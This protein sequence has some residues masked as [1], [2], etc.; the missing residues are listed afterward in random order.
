[1]NFPVIYRAGNARLREKHPLIALPKL[2]HYVIKKHNMFFGGL[3]MELL[4][5]RI[6]KSGKVLP[7][8]VLKIDSFLN[9]QM[10]PQLMHEMALR[11]EGV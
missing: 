6:L 4:E 7:G 11:C 10:D 8:G 2:A 3:H 1:M 9:H 5:Q